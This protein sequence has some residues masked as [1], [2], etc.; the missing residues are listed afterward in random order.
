M[1]YSINNDFDV[2]YIPINKVF[3]RVISRLND[4]TTM[5]AYA[6]KNT[7][8]IRFKEFNQPMTILKNGGGFLH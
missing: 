4:E 8:D 2:R 5:R 3:Q 7:Y 6:D 1:Y